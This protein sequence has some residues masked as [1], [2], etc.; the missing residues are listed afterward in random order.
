MSLFEK[1]NN[2]PKIFLCK[3]IPKNTTLIYII[4]T[5]YQNIKNLLHFV[6]YYRGTNVLDLNK[7]NE[8]KHP[9]KQ[10]TVRVLHFEF[11]PRRIMHTKISMFTVKY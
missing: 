9:N 10:L 2:T 8:K 5:V 4:K 1:K 3:K 11:R 6:A 7:L